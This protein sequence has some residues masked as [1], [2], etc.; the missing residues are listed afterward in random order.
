MS[1]NILHTLADT[2]NAAAN[3]LRTAAIEA[4]ELE[5][6]DIEAEAAADIEAETAADVEAEVD[7]IPKTAT[8]EKDVEAEAEIVEFID[9]VSKDKPNDFDERLKKAMEILKG[10]V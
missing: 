7:T 9:K 10:R 8:I 4:D 5:A 2:L 6:A 1:K 3:T